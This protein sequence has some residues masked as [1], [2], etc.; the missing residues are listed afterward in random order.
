M[1]LLEREEPLGELLG[2]LRRAEAGQGSTA[3][4]S[5]EAGIGKTTL[6]RAFAEL[7]GGRARLRGSGCD[8]GI[9]PRA[10]GPLRDVLGESL[11]GDRAFTAVRRGPA[12]EAPTVL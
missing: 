3:L 9:P 5:G 8:D 4:V 7:A 11:E 10:L 2:A 6:V 12:R 1:A